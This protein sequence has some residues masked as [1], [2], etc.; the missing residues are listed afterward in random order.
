MAK[1]TVSRPT[2]KRGHVVLAVLGIV[3][4][5]ATLLMYPRISSGEDSNVEITP[6][7]EA[8]VLD[9]MSEFFSTK[10]DEITAKVDEAVEQAKVDLGVQ[11]SKQDAA[12]MEEQFDAQSSQVLD[13]LLVQ[14]TIDHAQADCLIRALVFEAGG[15]PRLGKLWVLSVIQNRVDLKYRGMSTHCEVIFDD[16]QF[17]FANINPDRVP[18]YTRDLVEST[19]LVVD[20][21]LDRRKPRVYDITDCATHYLRTDWIDDTDWAKAAIEGKS[22]ANEPLEL[23]GVVGNHT[24]FGLPADVCKAK[25]LEVYVESNR[26]VESK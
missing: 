20:E 19:K 10:K 7:K 13:D 15:E 5:A 9:R 22:P 16:K 21:Y 25:K 12:S 8:G 6:V 2:V 14:T 11:V 17:S 24:F 23:K 4:M 26:Q 3:L 18:G 1:T